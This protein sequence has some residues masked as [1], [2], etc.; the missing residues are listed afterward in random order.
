MVNSDNGGELIQEI[1]YAIAAEYE[2]PDFTPRRIEAIRV[3]PGALAPLAG[4]YRMERG[5]GVTLRMTNGK[6]TSQASFE[7]AP[8]ELVPV[9][10]G[11]FV[12]LTRGWRFEV[13]GDSLAMIPGPGARIRGARQ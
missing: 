12:G 9:G 6:L 10:P 5:F 4:T 11:A 7:A 3:D 13:Q 2:W 1:L 8:E